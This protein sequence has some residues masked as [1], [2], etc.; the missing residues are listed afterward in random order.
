MKLLENI[1]FHVNNLYKYFISAYCYNCT[2]YIDNTECLCANCFSKII[3]LTDPH[4]KICG[5]MFPYKVEEEMMCAS[6]IKEAPFYDQARYLFAYTPESKNIIFKIKYHN[7]VHLAKFC[8]RLLSA[9][10][11]SFIERAD[12]II[13]V[14]MHFFKLI[15]RGFN[16]SMVL[17]KYL[18]KFSQK[19]Y[20]KYLLVKSK[21]TKSQSLL[22]RKAR[23]TNLKNTIK[24]KEKYKEMIKDKTILLIDDVITTGST[25]NECARILKKAGAKEVLVL[26]IA[27][28]NI[29]IFKK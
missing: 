26:A 9:K 10:F 4:C 1:K 27:K 14:P 28:T 29:N 6:C 16:Q 17:V 21:Y 7:Q 15:L 19:D 2:A 5:E 23:L 8:A 13:P 12:F 22:T 11:I 18:A 3:F 24:I 25:I 20:I